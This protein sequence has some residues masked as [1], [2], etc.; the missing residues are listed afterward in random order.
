LCG[1]ASSQTD[2]K[3]N[4]VGDI[5]PSANNGVVT[6][7]LPGGYQLSAEELGFDCKKLTGTMQVRILQIRGYDTNKKASAAARGMQTFAT[8]IWG[9]TKEGVDPDGQYQRDRAML[10]AYNRQL[11]AKQCPTFDL[12]RE[13]AATEDTT[14]TPVPRTK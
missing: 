10:E 5:S 6:G 3:P 7:A 14:P 12:A 13:L 11:A 4:L 2:T 1:C 9:G 8:P